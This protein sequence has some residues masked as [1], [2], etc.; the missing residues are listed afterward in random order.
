MEKSPLYHFIWPGN[1]PSSGEN[2]KIDT[3]RL[4]DLAEGLK[5]YGNV[6]DE[7]KKI[8]GGVN[9]VNQPQSPS[10]HMKGIKEAIKEAKE[11]TE[12]VGDK[13]KDQPKEKRKYSVLPDGN[14]IV[15]AEGEYNLAEAMV[16]ASNL[17]QQGGPTYYYQDPESDGFKEAKGPVIIHQPTPP[18]TWMVTTEGE[19]KKLQPGEPV[20]VKQQAPPVPSSPGKSWIINPNGSVEEWEPGK[21]IVI[22]LEAPLSSLP[23]TFPVQ[24]ADSQG[25][26]IGGAIL[27]PIPQFMEYASTMQKIKHDEEK[28]A[29]FMEFMNETKKEIPRIARALERETKTRETSKGLTAAPGSSEE[30]QEAVSEMDVRRCQHCKTVFSTPKGMVE[31]LCPNPK[32]PSNS[33]KES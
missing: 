13:G 14:I 17:K 7:L 30:V 21:P 6:G 19:V 27:L 12:V 25:N 23:A 1:K 33:P 29:T 16:M 31:V 3:E 24:P 20:V 22:K 18:D 8:T 4:K 10:E 15:D 2:P 9:M 32:C 28:H 26:P 11:L 5:A